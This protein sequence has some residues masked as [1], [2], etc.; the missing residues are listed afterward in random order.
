M[1]T[2]MA[3]PCVNPAAGRPGSFSMPGKPP[4][5]NPAAPP[6]AP[7][8]AA[9]GCPLGR[10]P[11]GA[12]P[13]L[14]GFLFPELSRSWDPP[15]APVRFCRGGGLP[16]RS[17]IQGAGAV[18]CVRAGGQGCKW[19]LSRIHTPF[20]EELDACRA[21]ERCQ[22]ALWDGEGSA[23]VSLSSRHPCVCVC[24]CVVSQPGANPAFGCDDVVWIYRAMLM[25]GS[26]VPSPRAV[27][28]DF[29]LQLRPSNSFH[30]WGV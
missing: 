28:K 12:A 10:W 6:H 19:L 26:P 3:Q 4:G 23:A 16:P 11:N 15:A 13:T 1:R 25:A 30:R 27:F 2:A 7:P 9:Q 21:S 20:W 5:G 14:P 22:R 29:P 8:S 17:S 18:S 24:V